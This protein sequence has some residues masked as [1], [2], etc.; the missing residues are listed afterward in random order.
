MACKPKK[1]RPTPKGREEAAAA[2]SAA[3]KTIWKEH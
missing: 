3:E 1:T 2:R